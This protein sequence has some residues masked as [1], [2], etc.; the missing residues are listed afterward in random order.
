L[1]SIIIVPPL[2]KLTLSEIHATLHVVA[3]QSF[4][5]RQIESEEAGGPEMI[6]CQ[7]AQHRLVDV[8]AQDAL[9][10]DVH[11]TIEGEPC[12]EINQPHRRIATDVSNAK[13]LAPQHVLA[14]H[15]EFPHVVILQ[16][17][18]NGRFSRP[19]VAAQNNQSRTRR[20]N[21]CHSEIKPTTPTAIDR[22]TPQGDQISI[23]A[24]N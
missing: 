12:N 1:E 20:T 17:A 10:H 6:S 8:T 4:V 18:G 14:D 15:R 11:A 5:E 23:L 7:R 13:D 22:A 19:A 16:L 2:L 9:Q 21:A 24:D 3:P